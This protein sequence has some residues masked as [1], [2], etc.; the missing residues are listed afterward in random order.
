MRVG[1][2][3]DLG[4]HPPSRPVPYIRRL[5]M[6]ACIQKRNRACTHS[7]MHKQTYLHS[8]ARYLYCT[9]QTLNM[10]THV[11]KNTHHAR[12]VCLYACLQHGV[13]R[14]AQRPAPMVV[15][16]DPSPSELPFRMG[17]AAQAGAKSG[18]G[19]APPRAV[20]QVSTVCAQ[21]SLLGD[22]S[23]LHRMNGWG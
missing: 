23:M 7:H 16:Q 15:F 22:C 19:D 18:S 20:L 6:W 1:R 9:R 10:H 3:R 13:N 5:C 17:G 14:D 4:P 8:D 11:H 21:S 12:P 2:G